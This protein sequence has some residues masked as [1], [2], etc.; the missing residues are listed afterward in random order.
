MKIMSWS[1]Y[2]HQTEAIVKGNEGK[3]F[4]VTSGTGSGKSL[5]YIS[6]I[7]NHLLK[8]PNRPGIKAIIV[9]PLNALINSQEAALIG[10]EENYRKRTGSSL[11]FTF[12]KYTG[13]EKQDVRAKVIANPPDILL[14]NYMMLELL[15]V[16]KADEGLRKSFLDSIEFLVYDELHV[17]KGRQGADVSLL[18]RR[19]KAAAKNKN[20]LCIGTSATMASGTID[21]QKMEVAKVATRFFATDFFPTNVIVESL[22]YSTNEVLPTKEELQSAVRAEIKDLS[23]KAILE[24]PIAIWLERTVAVR[25]EG[26]HKRRNEPKS[27]K[28]IAAE[29]SL[30]TGISEPEAEKRIIEILIWA[31]SLNIESAKEN[32]KDTI[33]P[34]KLHQFISQTGYVYV[35]L[36]DADNRFVTLEPNPFVKLSESEPE[37]PVFQTVFS[38][39]SGVEFI[40]VRKEFSDSKLIFRDFNEIQNPKNEDDLKANDG[41]KV[42]KVRSRLQDHYKDGYILFNKGFQFDLNE[43]LELLP[44]GWKNKAGDKIDPTKDFLLPKEIYVSKDGSFSDAPNGG[45]QGL[46]HASSP[47]LRPNLRPNLFRAQTKRKIK[48]YISR[49]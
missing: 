3:G 39:V 32:K 1:I 10:F 35:T 25:N 30:E 43:F 26:E 27:L 22:T 49:Q 2:K 16:R 13:Q 7:F 11:P 6:T 34:F 12:A 23:K 48:T 28:R 40:C 4:V 47:N 20:I 36:E 21:E 31:E 19:I 5:T 9:Y 18:N 14:T 33:L 24:N 38:R 37:V 46:V 45:D 44:A 41:N 29:L 42:K 15:M 8:N 17:Y